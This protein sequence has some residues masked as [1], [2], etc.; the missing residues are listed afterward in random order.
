M[1]DA[2]MREVES[3]EEVRD[4]IMHA[5]GEAAQR[6]HCAALARF[7]RV[8]SYLSLSWAN[9]QDAKQLQSILSKVLDWSGRHGAPA[10]DLKRM[11]SAV[12]VLFNYKFHQEMSD[13]PVVQ[14]VV[15]KHIRDDLPVRTP[16]RLE[17]ELPQL[18]EHI[19]QM[20]SN[21]DLTHTLL[22]QKCVVLVMAT[23]CAR[24]TEMQQFALEDSNPTDD[25]RRWE[26]I[27]RVKNR[28]YRQP[29]I[30]HATR[31]DNINPVKA[32]SE[33]R[34]RVRKQREMGEMQSNTFWYT[35]NGTVMGYVEIRQAAQRLLLAA[36]I[37]DRRPYHIK[38]ATISWLY[39]QHVPAD[40]IIRFIRHALSSTTY[41]E[42]YLS[43]DLGERCTDVI[44]S[45]AMITEMR[46]ASETEE[47]DEG[48]G[49]EG[50]EE[51]DPLRTI[52]DVIDTAML[53]SSPKMQLARHGSL[54]LSEN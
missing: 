36:G 19:A 35:S 25:S 15:R 30:L 34:E 41:M 8:C 48:T 4:T 24:F 50:S 29:I 5:R 45:T 20:G 1:W 46:S 7:T 44:E 2:V 10:N 27:V 9:I 42:Y 53:L 39:K 14:S 18:L 49:E 54:R 3:D 26:F 33:L 38:H 6:A 17:W 52:A 22:V 37:R 21:Q 31:N 16:L 40:Q 47:G 23:T 28:D 32:M 43:D 11:K 51:K 13:D 12:S